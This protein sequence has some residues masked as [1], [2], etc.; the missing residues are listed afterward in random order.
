MALNQTNKLVWIVD[1]IYK[2]GKIT[3]EELN[4]RWMNNV[5]LSG[6]EEMLKRTFHK[7]KWNIFDTFGLMI[8]C[9]KTAP[10]RYYIENVDDMKSD[11]IENWLLSTYSVHHAGPPRAKR[12]ITFFIPALQIRQ[13]IVTFAAASK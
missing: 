11:G 3:F 6:G 12:E 9:E 8:E 4:R 5:D 2:A 13:K 7:W 10:Y 1:T